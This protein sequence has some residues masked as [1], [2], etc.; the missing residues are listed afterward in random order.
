MAIS[1][2]LDPPRAYLDRRM[3]HVL[4]LLGSRSVFGF[5]AYSFSL[6]SRGV[7]KEPARLS[8]GMRLR[9][10]ALEQ[11]LRSAPGRTTFLCL[12]DLRRPLARNRVARRCQ[13]H[14]SRGTVN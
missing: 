13:I 2:D 7:W 3:N 5:L 6:L 1:H 14:R 9:V 4:G 8:P 10:N 11:R 12:N